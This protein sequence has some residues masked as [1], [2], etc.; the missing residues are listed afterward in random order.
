MLRALSYYPY[1]TIIMSASPVLSIITHGNCI[2]GLASAYLFWEAHQATHD[3][4]VY[5]VAPGFA[6]TWPAVD[7]VRG[8]HLVFVDVT[9]GDRMAAYAAAASSVRIVDHHPTA[10]DHSA[11][12]TAPSCIC[13]D[14][15]ATRL[16]WDL[17]HPGVAAPDWVSFVNR[18]DTWTDIDDEL[19]AFREI[20]KPIA[21]SAVSASPISA[22]TAFADLVNVRM[23]DEVQRVALFTEGAGIYATKMAELEALLSA[24]PQFHGAIDAELQAKWNLPAA[25]TGQTVFIADTS[26]QYIGT[27]LFDTTA[28]C[29][30]VFDKHAGTNIFVNYHKVSWNY[31]GT[32]FCKYVYHARARPDTVDLTNCT[33]L[34]GHPSAAGGQH[35]PLTGVTVCPFVV[36]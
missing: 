25:W 18:I 24:C 7:A 32:P 9:C 15:C 33:V 19:L 30:H 23:L 22:I 17:L 27:S 34:D 3:V 31:K 35:Q 4:R 13:T 14:F 8:T 16:A 36:A 1:Y 10:A 12:T 21:N 2:D 6:G 29:Q 5:P 20:V 26:R 28:V 11:L